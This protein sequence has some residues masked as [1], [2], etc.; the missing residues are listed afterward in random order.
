ML[1]VNWIEMPSYRTP[2]CSLSY[3]LHFMTLPIIWLVFLPLSSQ[4]ASFLSPAV[5]P[6][7]MPES[8]YFPTRAA[9]VL[10]N[11]DA[12]TPLCTDQTRH[13]MWC[14]GGCGDGMLPASPEDKVLL[15]QAFSTCF[16]EGSGLCEVFFE[17]MPMKSQGYKGRAWKAWAQ[18]LAREFFFVV[19]LLLFNSIA[20]FWLLL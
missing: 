14:P 10:T 15:T 3:F 6:R 13:L 2:A 5:P 7:T 12:I 19:V 1:L 11:Y 16:V 4:M 18:P 17:R 9:S 8:I 20:L